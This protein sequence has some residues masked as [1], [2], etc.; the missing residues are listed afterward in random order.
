M[1]GTYQDL[2]LL[3]LSL[4]PAEIFAVL[5]LVTVLLE[6]SDSQACKANTC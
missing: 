1:V 3:L 4:D 5:P 2:H 6:V